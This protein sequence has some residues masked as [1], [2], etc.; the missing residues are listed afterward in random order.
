MFRSLAVLTRG[1]PA[2]AFVIA[3][4]LALTALWAGVAW[5]R[6]VSGQTPAPASAAISGVVVDGVTGGPLGSAFVS[7]V[8]RGSGPGSPRGE[9]RYQ[10]ADPAGRF[11]FSA[12]PAGTYRLAVWKVGYVSHAAASGATSTPVVTLRSGQ[13]LRDLRLA[14][15]RPSAITGTVV[16]A[17]GDPVVGAH[18]RVIGERIVG[19]RAHPFNGPI[20]E[21]D[22]RGAY[23]V[24]N[25]APGRYLV[26][27]LGESFGAD[28]S[29]RE[30][31]AHSGS[32][33]PPM[34]FPEARSRTGALPVDLGPGEVRSGVDFRV[35]PVPT[36][37]VA[38]RIEGDR[39]ALA[40][41]SLRLVPA[42]DETM[43]LGYDVA[44]IRISSDGT[45]SFASVPAGRYVLEA[46]PTLARFGLGMQP[47]PDMRDRTDQS[48]ALPSLAMRVPGIGEDLWLRTSVSSPGLGWVREAVEVADRDILDLQLAIRPTASVSGTIR[49]EGGLTSAQKSRPLNLFAEPVNPRLGM[50]G[51]IA[52]FGDDGT[53]AFTIHGLLPGR[54]FLIGFALPGVIKSIVWNG[55][56]YTDQ[57]FDTAL[58]Q[59]Y[60]GVVVTVTSQRVRI[61]GT[62]RDAR[63]VPV[64]DAVVIC[65]PSNPDDWERFGLVPRRLGSVH[66]DENGGFAFGSFGG[67]TGGLPAG[68]YSLVAVDESRADAWQDRGF[69]AAA[70]RVA[71]S[72]GVEWGDTP[73]VDLRLQETALP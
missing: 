36:H 59:D 58:V 53:A 52:R 9:S 2:A 22:D 27:Y 67:P 1:L 43:A 29:S 45:F 54:Y 57:P 17:H 72:V 11:V 26:L 13:W 24:P 37:R 35:Q 34:F 46:L 62:V 73:T 5:P 69:L 38:G 50:P 42:A 49:F 31:L 21:T 33:Y 71:T 15:W 6:L 3:E 48:S 7:L 66:T 28:G 25:L 19:G 51:A 65:F 12:L 23:R 68:Q 70:S 30:A 44:T 32:V 64:S 4:G 8:G 56:D 20:V 41:A 39:R 63:G 40:D 47:D 60:T 55:R 14:L 18:L 10:Q 61:T 16:D